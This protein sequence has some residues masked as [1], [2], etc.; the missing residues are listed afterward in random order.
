MANGTVKRLEVF[1][2][3][4]LADGLPLLCGKAVYYICISNVLFVNIA[5]WVSQW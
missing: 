5:I 3:N 4:Y 2:K 1:F